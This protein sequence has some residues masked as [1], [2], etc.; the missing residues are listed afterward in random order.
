MMV[1]MMLPSAAPMILLVL[2]VYRRRG[3]DQARAAGV[4]F[5]AG[6]LIAWTAFSAAAAALQ[7]GLHRAAL[8]AA[9][10]RLRSAA[11][12]GAV[13]I[14]AGVYQWLPIKNACLGHCQ[15]PLRYLTEHWREGRRGG[16]MMGLDHGVFC[17]G[18]CW[19]LMVLLFV[20]GVMNL[21]WIAALAV[22]VL[23]EKLAMRGELLTRV[24]GVAVAVWG[25]YLLVK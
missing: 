13:L 1:A 15:S 25:L 20:L 24:A 5:V 14:V 21:F 22:F 9:D 12:S 7:V 6:Y 3:D 11:V 2:G 8:V 17:V 18:C 23:L 19:L 16:L 10:M 4:M